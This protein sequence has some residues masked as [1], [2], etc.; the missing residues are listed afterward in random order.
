MG[1]LSAVKI[2]KKCLNSTAR[3]YLTRLYHF[4]LGSP[5][6][7]EELSF[8]K[9]MEHRRTERLKLR[10]ERRVSVLNSTAPMQRTE[11]LNLSSAGIYFV[12]DLPLV[13]GTPVQLLFKMPLEVTHMP[14]A[15]W[16]CT[17][18]VVHI[19]P[20]SYPKGSLAVGVQFDCYEVV[21]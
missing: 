14:A 6:I 17:G 4:S 8:M 16:V 15:N 12:T 7:L 11:S 19:K 20:V 13:R 2:C 3:V 1:A 21:T 9:P 10:I 5:L 18:H